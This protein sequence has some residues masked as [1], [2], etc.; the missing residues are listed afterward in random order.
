MEGEYFIGF[1]E[2]FV[3]YVDGDHLQHAR[4]R[5]LQEKT[6]KGSLKHNAKDYNMQWDTLFPLLQHC[7][8]LHN[9]HA[10]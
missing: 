7:F 6:S 5:N 2:H 10:E 3:I 4:F 1:S 9:T 8:G